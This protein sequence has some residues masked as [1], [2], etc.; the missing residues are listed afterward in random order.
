MTTPTIVIAI[1]PEQIV[2][3]TLAIWRGST[4]RIKPAITNIQPRMVM[5][6]RQSV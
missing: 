3:A 6:T 2:V 4:M 1:D 5:M